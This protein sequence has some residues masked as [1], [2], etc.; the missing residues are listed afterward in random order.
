MAALQVIGKFFGVTMR[1]V[2]TIVILEFLFTAAACTVGQRMSGTSVRTENCNLQS[3]KEHL[4]RLKLCLN[5]SH[6]LERAELLL[7]EYM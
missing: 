5:L 3:I 7:A 6:C 2:F 4:T 1:L